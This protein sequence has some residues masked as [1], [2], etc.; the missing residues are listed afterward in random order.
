MGS[1]YKNILKYTK[2][3]INGSFDYITNQP[4]ELYE[5]LRKERAEG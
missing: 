3:M 5:F 2:I 4:Q 1:N